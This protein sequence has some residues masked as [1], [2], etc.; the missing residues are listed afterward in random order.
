MSPYIRVGSIHIKRQLRFKIP[1]DIL[2]PFNIIYRKQGFS[3][4]SDF[5]IH[6]LRKEIDRYIESHPEI[7]NEIEM[8]EKLYKL[9]LKEK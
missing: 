9:R 1:N 7:K 2:I 3:R 8:Y 6:I 5:I 4:A